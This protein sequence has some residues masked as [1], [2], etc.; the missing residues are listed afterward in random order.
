MEFGVWVWKS[1]GLLEIHCQTAR[2]VQ[3]TYNLV[4]WPWEFLGLFCPVRSVLG[5]EWVLE[6]VLEKFWNLARQNLCV[7]LSSTGTVT[8]SEDLESPF[9]R[10][11]GYILYHIASTFVS[12]HCLT[13]GNTLASFE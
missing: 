3:Y 8:C 2:N 9:C 11:G 4:G 13:D 6:K 12:D 1:F 5:W 7:A 10:F